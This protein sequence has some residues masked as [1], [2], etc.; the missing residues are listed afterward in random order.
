MKS[1]VM[2]ASVTLGGEVTCPAALVSPRIVITATN[3]FPSLSQVRGSDYSSGRSGSGSGYTTTV[4]E[5]P[6]LMVKSFHDL[7]LLY[8]LYL[9][10]LR[11]QTGQLVVV[12]QDDQNGGQLDPGHY[13]E[14]GRA[15]EELQLHPACHP[16]LAPQ[17]PQHTRASKGSI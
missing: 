4:V 6:A 5:H 3:C 8:L 14:E 7:Y 15:V 11:S 12:G 13:W 16:Q 9:Q 1:P 10:E 2:Q 17:E